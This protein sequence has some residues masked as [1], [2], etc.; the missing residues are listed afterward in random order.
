MAEARHD[1]F[2][3]PNPPEILMQRHLLDPLRGV[4]V[5]NHCITPESRIQP[6]QKLGK[7]CYKPSLF[8]LD[9][10]AEIR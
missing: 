2:N 4:A 9:L 7:L 3:H 10:R 1:Q 5:D 8:S 6:I